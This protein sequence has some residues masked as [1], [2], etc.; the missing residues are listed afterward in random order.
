V[1]RDPDTIASRAIDALLAPLDLDLLARA[2]YHRATCNGEVS[3]E[4]AKLGTWIRSAA[5]ALTSGLDEHMSECNPYSA[6]WEWEW[7]GVAD[8][9]LDALQA[10][11]ESRLAD[12]ASVVKTCACCRAA[13]TA[14]TWET[15]PKVGTHSGLEL[16]NC[17]CREGGAT[18]AIERV[19]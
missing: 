9:L 15:L 4:P 1:S 17:P 16:R 5:A 12:L 19:G 3:P 10:E 2:E 13:Y 8:T 14:A 6:E 7:E 18:L 11:F